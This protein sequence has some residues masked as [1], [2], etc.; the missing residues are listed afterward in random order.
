RWPW[1]TVPEE[2][3][4]EAVELKSTCIPHD[5]EVYEVLYK[6][7][8]HPH[9]VCRCKNSPV[10][11]GSL[12]IRIGQ[13]PVRAR[14][15]V[16]S[17][18]AFASPDCHAAT[19]DNRISIYGDCLLRRPT[20][21]FHE[22]AHILD[23]NPD[24][25]GKNQHCYSTNSS[26]WKKIV[27]KDSCLANPYSKTGYPEAYA[28]IAVLVAY[29]LNIRKLEKSDCMKGQLDKVTQQ[30]GGQSGFLKNVKGAKCSGSVNRHKTVCM[31]SAARNQGKCKG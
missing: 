9:I 20:D 1:G 14:Q 24:I 8:I 16:H 22:V 2:C 15:H 5:L 10:P 21:I 18:H 4:H 6:D 17:W 7:C 27:A 26:E 28:E 29:H 13:V 31:G 19:A 25:A 12:A 11:I 3:F 23:C 30:L